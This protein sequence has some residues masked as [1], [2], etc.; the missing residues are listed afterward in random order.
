LAHEFLASQ[1]IK[2]LK[3]ILKSNMPYEEVGTHISKLGMP[4]LY[5]IWMS[6]HEP[7]NKIM[8]EKVRLTG[9]GRTRTRQRMEAR[10]R[11]EGEVF[12]R[13]EGREEERRERDEERTDQRQGNKRKHDFFGVRRPGTTSKIFD[14]ATE[15][16]VNFSNP[17]AFLA[18][19]GGRLTSVQHFFL[20]SLVLF[21]SPE[22]VLTIFRSF[23]APLGNLQLLRDALFPDLSSFC[24]SLPSL[25]SHH[26][27]VSLLKFCGGLWSFGGVVGGVVAEFWWGFGG[28]SAEFWR[29]LVGIWRGFGG[30]LVGF[31][32]G[33]GGILA[34]F[35]EFGL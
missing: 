2:K 12:R 22:A 33:S 28:V 23:V 19:Q 24:D 16:Y 29:T 18:T 25:Q 5:Q 9:K 17:L 8:W 15:R 1:V 14:V 31:W 4:E 30:V 13:R 26:E 27:I 3:L 7:Q 6:L 11:S 35:S 21:S 32:R 10:T 20:T 34:D